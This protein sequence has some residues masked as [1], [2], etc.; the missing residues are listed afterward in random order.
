MDRNGGLEIALAQSLG[1]GSPSDIAGSSLIWRVRILSITDFEI[2]VECPSAMGRAIDIVEGTL[3][4]AAMTIGQNR[5]MF[6][7]SALGTRPR[8][9]PNEPG[10]LRLSAP[11]GV[12]RCQRRN[13][14]RISTTELTVPHVECCPVLDPASVAA[15][16]V[17]NRAAARDGGRSLARADTELISQPEVG[18]TFSARLV[19]VGGGGAGLLVDRGESSSLDRSKLLWLR[20]DLRPHIATPLGMAARVVHTHLDSAGNI[21]AGVAFE[22]GSNTAH[23][24]FVVEQICEY[25]ARVQSLQEH[26]LR[27]AG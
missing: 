5:W 26:R 2:Q 6:H 3:L 12:E 8:T 10:V 22:F 21:Y 23:R 19:N 18:P 27:K 15:A 14:Y 25:A 11:S 17:A 9:R 1:S 20:V 4:V 24:D 7:T 13:F 16:E